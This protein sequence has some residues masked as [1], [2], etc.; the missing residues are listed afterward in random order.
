M[1]SP[2]SYLSSPPVLILLDEELELLLDSND[3]SISGISYNS[4]ITTIV[5]SETAITSSSTSPWLPQIALNS[6][7]NSITTCVF[8]IK[9]VVEQMIV[10]A[11]WFF[12]H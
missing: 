9:I 7:K 8:I 10:D 11:F 2:S 1:G 12:K 6:L 5:L 3:V 4:G